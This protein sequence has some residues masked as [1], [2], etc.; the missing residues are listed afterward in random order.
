M[1]KRTPHVLVT[2][3]ALAL[4]TGT[5]ATAPKLDASAVTDA[6]VWVQVATAGT[7]KGYA[8]GEVQFTFDKKLFAQ[9]I[10]NFRK[11]PSF[12]LGADGVGAMDVVAWDFHHASE[13]PAV[14]GTIPQ[15]GAPAQ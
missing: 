7:Y 12:K 2:N 14:S 9:V 3:V 13:M 11:H 8:G 1:A 4:A 15:S 10:A 5:G 6:P